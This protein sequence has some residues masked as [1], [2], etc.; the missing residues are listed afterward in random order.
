S[1]G[2]D[3]SARQNMAVLGELIHA[4]ESDQLSL[5]YQPK[6]DIATGVIGGAEALMRWN[7]PSKG[8]IP[9][10]LFIPRAEQSTLIQLITRFALE[11]AMQQAVVW[12]GRG[13]C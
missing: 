2:A 5:H 7:H 4:L 10:G 12:Q 3:A 8:N 9:P 6:V 1:S 11:Q 13:I